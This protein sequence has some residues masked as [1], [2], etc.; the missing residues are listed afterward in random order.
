LFIFTYAIGYGLFNILRLGENFHMLF[1]RNQ[2]YVY[3]LGHIL[4]RPFDPLLPF[5]DRI[6]EYFWIMGPSALAFLVVLGIL[7]GMRNKRKETLIVLVWAFLPILAV[8]E[9]SKV[10]TARYIFFSVPFVF[11]L[12]ALS[13]WENRES[14]SKYLKALLIIFVIHALL[15]DWQLLTNPQAA[16]LPRS[17]RSGYLEEWTAGHGIKEVAEFI[18]EEQRSNPEE[19]ILVGTE[20]YFGTL[21]DA[22]Q[23][24]LADTPEVTVIGVGQPIKDI[25]KQLLESKAFGNKTY[26]VVNS[27][28]FEGSLEE[29]NLELLAV[30]AKAVKPDGHRESLLFFEVK[31]LTNEPDL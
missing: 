15:L 8:A 21:P 4:E 1:L 3:S 23:A 5:L 13:F 24:Y 18:R 9:Y 26:L 29:D 7:L 30:Y 10:M 14:F 20:G 17:E 12:A 6:L 22:L 27:S 11:I 25:P 19:K 31:S 16:N 28:R 2:D